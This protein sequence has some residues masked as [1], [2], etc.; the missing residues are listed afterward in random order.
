MSPAHIEFIQALMREYG[1]HQQLQTILQH[2]ILK[3]ERNLYLEAFR[4]DVEEM[5]LETLENIIADSKTPSDIINIVTYELTYRPRRLAIQ[6]ALIV[7]ACK[8]CSDTN[9]SFA[10]KLPEFKEKEKHI[11][12]V[13][14]TREESDIITLLNALDSQDTRLCKI[15]KII[16]GMTL[17]RTLANWKKPLRPYIASIRFS[18]QETLSSLYQFK[19]LAEKTLFNV[20]PHIIDAIL[21]NFKALVDQCTLQDCNT[22]IRIHGMCQGKDSQLANLLSTR[23]KHIGGHTDMIDRLAE[24]LNTIT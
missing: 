10:S 23:M 24:D 7:R 11:V 14:E 17:S 3:H 19:R 22:L 15:D 4:T 18:K 21:R 1:G 8:G 5:S 16:V 13:E 6:D 9:A 2:E 12:E 20:K